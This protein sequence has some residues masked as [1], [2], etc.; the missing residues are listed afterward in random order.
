MKT[1][2]VNGKEYRISGK[3]SRYLSLQM[4]G[5]EWYIEDMVATGSLEDWVEFAKNKLQG[6]RELLPNAKWSTVIVDHISVL[7]G[8]FRYNYYK[9]LN[10]ET[11]KIEET[12]I[13]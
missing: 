9:Q 2:M 12:V 8:G 3:P 4:N 6:V 7:Y 1:L 5:D 13:G 11:G 10:V